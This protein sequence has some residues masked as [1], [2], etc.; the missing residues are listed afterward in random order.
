MPVLSRHNKNIASCFHRPK[1]AKIAFYLALKTCS[2]ESAYTPIH[3]SDDK[4]QVRN[5]WSSPSFVY[6]VLSSGENYSQKVHC[7]LYLSIA[8]WFSQ[9]VFFLLL[10]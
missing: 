9:A 10:K 4:S 1:F 5:Y 2:H 3:K 7:W 6:A 8:V